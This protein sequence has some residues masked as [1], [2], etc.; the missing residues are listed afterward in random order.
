MIGAPGMAPDPRWPS[1]IVIASSE[2]TPEGERRVGGRHRSLTGGVL[3][4]LKR[5]DEQS[6]ERRGA[7]HRSEGIPSWRR[8]RKG[9]GK[10]DGDPPAESSMRTRAA[11]ASA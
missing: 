8:P 6:E 4:A 9:W 5:I 3:A 2:L 7:R 10:G 1:S 11:A